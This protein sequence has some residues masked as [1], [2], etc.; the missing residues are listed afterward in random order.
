MIFNK[1]NKNEITEE[2]VIIE[3]NTFI[4]EKNNEIE[5][6]YKKIRDRYKNDLVCDREYVKFEKMRIS[7]E[8][9][10]YES[11]SSKYYKS[12]IIG[13]MVAITQL[14]IQEFIELLPIKYEI[15]LFIIVSMYIVVF[16]CFIKTFMKE[17]V[18][19]NSKSLMLYIVLEVLD[20]IEEEIEYRESVK[21]MAVSKV[22]DSFSLKKILKLFI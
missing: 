2:K 20:E 15:R 22:E 17:R 19:D 11:D 3:F 1:N 18:K 7:R 14:Y 13:L 12:I 5:S 6:I 4:N 16:I 8:L 10:K 21:E 9:N